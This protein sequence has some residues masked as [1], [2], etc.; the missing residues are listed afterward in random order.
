MQW[1]PKE[2]SASATLPAGMRLVVVLILAGM[3]ATVAIPTSHGYVAGWALAGAL[4]AV[5]AAAACWGLT[6]LGHGRLADLLGAGAVLVVVACWRHADG[7]SHSGF[8]P[9]V[10]LPVVWLALRRRRVAAA[11]T[12]AAAAMTLWAPVLVVGA[13]QYPTAEWRPVVMVLA[14]A[15]VA[16]LLVDHLVGRLA[17]AAGRADAARAALDRAQAQA[18]LGS[19]TSDRTTGEVT[20][21]DQMWRLLGRSPQGSAPGMGTFAEHVAGS[22]QRRF[23]D[24]V[25]DL[26]PGSALQDTFAVR[27]DDGVTRFLMLS[28]RV[29]TGADGHLRTEGTVLDVTRV[30][31]LEAELSS[32]TE[33]LAR[34][35]DSATDQAVLAVGPDGRITLWNDGAERLT[36]YPAA[37]ALGRR[38]DILQRMVGG[39]DLRPTDAPPEV[40]PRSGEWECRRRDGTPFVARLG[41][42]PLRSLDGTVDGWIGIATDVTEERRAAE[43]LA[44]SEERLRVSFDAAPVGMALVPVAGRPGAGTF[45]R[46]NRALAELVGAEGPDALVGTRTWDLLTARGAAT[47]AAAVDAHRAGRP[48]TGELVAEM[49]R[50]DGTTF[51]ARIRYADVLGADGRP[52][53]RITSV[54]DVSLRE[55]ARRSLEAALDQERLATEH[56]REVDAVRSDFVSMVSHELRTPLT[57]IAG[58]VEMLVDG[59]GGLLPEPAVSMLGVVER[60]AERLL[61]LIDDL[62]TLSRIDA[63]AMGDVLVPVPVAALVAGAIEAV[64]PM[65][66]RA[67]LHLEVDLDVGGAEVEGDPQ[68]LERVILNLLSN[69]AKFTPEGG[70]VRVAAWTAAG[71]VAVRVSDEGMGI[72]L[73]E[74]PRLFERFFRSSTSRRQEVPGT[75]LGLPIARSIVERHGGTIAV[76]SAPGEG[77]SFTVTLPLLRG[78]APAPALQLA[79]A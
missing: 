10:D 60:N 40:L 61:R 49:R 2:P 35:L 68:H 77:A 46:V 44:V 53:H 54:E 17:D 38:L 45:V 33:R 73:D 64:E 70:R 51:D 11:A 75:G 59:D 16:G 14:V 6:R 15:A 21:S 4:V 30:T 52:E 72:P 8:S 3:A 26:R 19:W 34:L 48:L 69:A 41:V 20:F 78:V 28:G 25:A 62:L 58:Y 39:P 18:G 55:A 1:T 29:F 63:D 74:Q 42:A 65:L 56:L 7:G 36:G 76:E 79:E 9:L 71:E 27:G 57:S 31:Q 37:E 50:A 13:P 22:D 5:G 47:V 43:E 32:T 66:E 23:A 24:L 12:W 67:G